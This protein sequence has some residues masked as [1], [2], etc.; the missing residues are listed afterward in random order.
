MER[1]LCDWEIVEEIVCIVNKDAK[2]LYFIH[3]IYAVISKA[4]KY[5]LYNNSGSSKALILHCTQL[6][7]LK[8]L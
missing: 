1:G 6:P 7:R 4:V 5:L 2:Y 3:L 8:S